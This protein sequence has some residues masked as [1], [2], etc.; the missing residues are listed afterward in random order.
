MYASQ[1]ASL[2]CANAVIDNPCGTCQERI[3]DGQPCPM[4]DGCAAGSY[5]NQQGMCAPGPPYTAPKPLGAACAPTDTCADFGT[6]QAGICALVGGENTECDGSVACA[7]GYGCALS[8]RRC[9]ALPPQGQACLQIVVDVVTDDT[10]CADG[11]CYRD[12]ADAPGMCGPYAKLGEP[13]VVPI[14]GS[15]YQNVRKCEAGTHCNGWVNPQAP[16]CATNGIY[17]A[18]CVDASECLDG[19]ACQ[20]PLGEST[21]DQSKRTC[22][23]RGNLGDLCDAEDVCQ[24]PFACENGRCVPGPNQGLFEQRCGK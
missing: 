1:C 14:A 11:A 12:A 16:T 7:K 21:C 13:C 2:Y 23:K 19:F 24:G 20:C 5:C 15:Q 9:H 17:G 6:C 3:A 18:A 4:Y 8:D 22:H 10:L